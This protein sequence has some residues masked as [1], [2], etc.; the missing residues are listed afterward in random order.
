[1]EGPFPYSAFQNI[2]NFAEIYRFSFRQK[3]LESFRQK[4]SN[5][6]LSKIIR[7]NAKILNPKTF[8]IFAKFSVKFG[9]FSSFQYSENFSESAENAETVR[10]GGMGYFDI[11]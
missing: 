7:E 10:T 11:G 3:V 9:R 6:P 4:C 1:M 5:T 8:Q 2:R